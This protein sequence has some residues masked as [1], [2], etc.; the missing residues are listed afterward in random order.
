MDLIT[1]HYKP[2]PY[3]SISHYCNIVAL[4]CQSSPVIWQ[5]GEAAPSVSTSCGNDTADL[6]LIT[7]E[8]Q[9]G[10]WELS[11]WVCRRTE[12]ERWSADPL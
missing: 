2:P 10:R 5:P 11:E 7:N 6:P 8:A 12:V 4:Q 3:G 9:R 1:L